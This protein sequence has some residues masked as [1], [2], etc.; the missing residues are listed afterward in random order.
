[1]KQT[2]ETCRFWDIVTEDADRDAFF[3]HRYPPAITLP[4]VR[5]ARIFQYPTTFGFDSCGEWQPKRPARV[6]LKGKT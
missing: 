3:C 6:N 1:M 2:C 4:G 5:T